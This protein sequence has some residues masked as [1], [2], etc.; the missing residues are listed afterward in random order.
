M[1]V[2][3]LRVSAYYCNGQYRWNVMKRLS[4]KK[5]TSNGQSPLIPHTLGEAGR[6]AACKNWCL[7]LVFRVKNFTFRL[8][9]RKLKN[10][11]SC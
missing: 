2:S 4:G 9:D 8:L 6:L 7:S 5:R 3:D 11:S 10:L 1:Q